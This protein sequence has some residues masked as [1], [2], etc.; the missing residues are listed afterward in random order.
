MTTRSLR[1][2]QQLQQADQRQA[3]VPGADQGV[4]HEY[5][6]VRSPPSKRPRLRGPAVRILPSRRGTRY[7]DALW[8]ELCPPF[9]RRPRGSAPWGVVVA[10]RPS[11]RHP[12]H[13][14]ARSGG[15]GRRRLAP[16]PDPRAAT[17][18]SGFGPSMASTGRTHPLPAASTVAPSQTPAARVI[19]S[20][21][22]QV[23]LNFRFRTSQSID[24]ANLNVGRSDQT[25]G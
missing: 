3:D 14:A 25:G 1:S 16:G 10:G 2:A 22:V 5:H 18:R 17:H 7:P 19:H 11:S 23:L 6:H 9:V 4:E 24:F 12:L 21:K 15:Q 8:G 13:G 20:G